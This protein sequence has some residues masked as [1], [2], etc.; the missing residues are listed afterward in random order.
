MNHVQLLTLLILSNNLILS[1][2]E[3][4][5]NSPGEVNT[6]NVYTDQQISYEV[7]HR[8]MMVLNKSPL[9]ITVNGNELGVDPRP[10]KPQKRS[11]DQTISP[12]VQVKRAQ[13]HDHFNELEIPIITAPST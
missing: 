5:L 2:Q 12:I 13:I 10:R 1:A 6:I 9:S 11:V 7:L 8:G 4:T 3:F